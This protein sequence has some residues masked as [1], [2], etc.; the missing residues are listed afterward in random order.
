MLS[1]DIRLDSLYNGVITAGSGANSSELDVE[2]F[3]GNI[4]INVAARAG[5]TNSM[6]ITVE[7]S[8]TSGSGFEE[9]PA[10]ALFN[11]LTG[12]ADTFDAV[13]TAATDQT[14]GLNRQQL[15]RYVRVVLAG[16]TITQNTAITAA[17]QPQMT[18]F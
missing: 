10:S 15:K 13:T 6:A 12:E 8:E 5:G 11:P 18:E 4:F 16:T 7:H 3:V 1:F 9:V 2:G 17:G 14:L